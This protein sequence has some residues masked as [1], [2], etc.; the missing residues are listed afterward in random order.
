MIDAKAMHWRL[1]LIKNKSSYPET[2]YEDT[3]EYRADFQFMGVA[4][5]ELLGEVDR[6]TKDNVELTE[7]VKEHAL[8]K[9][10]G[11]KTMW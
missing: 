1:D 2:K 7:K 4:C 11:S 9:L 5:E 3:M 6:L 8:M 10:T